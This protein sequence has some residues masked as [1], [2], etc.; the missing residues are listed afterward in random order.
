MPPAS[1][2]LLGEAWSSMKA[3]TETERGLCRRL[4]M[5]DTMRIWRILQIVALA[6]SALGILLQSYEA[7]V[8]GRDPEAVH[9]LDAP[10]FSRRINST[11]SPSHKS[12]QSTVSTQITS[13]SWIAEHAGEPISPHDASSTDTLTCP[14]C[15]NS[16]YVRSAHTRSDGAFVAR[17]FSHYPG[18]TSRSEGGSGGCTGESDIHQRYKSVT[19]SKLQHHFDEYITTI[20]TE[21]TIG[22]RRADL[23]ATFT[24]DLGDRE[25]FLPTHGAIGTKLAVE[26]QHR[27][28]QK[29]KTAVTKHFLNHGYSVLWLEETQFSGK[30]VK[31][32][33]GPGQ[34]WIPVYPNILDPTILDNTS[35]PLNWTTHSELLTDIDTSATTVPAAVPPHWYRTELKQHLATTGAGPQYKRWAALF[36]ELADQYRRRAE[37]AL[38]DPD[39]LGQKLT[40]RL[41][42]LCRATMKTHASAE[43]IPVK[44]A[45]CG[46][47]RHHEDDQYR[48]DP[49]HIICWRNQPT[50][51]SNRP[52]K[53]T[54]DDDFAIDCP[55]FSY[56]PWLDEHTADEMNIHPRLRKPW[57]IDNL[58]GEGEITREQRKA[59]LKY[60]YYQTWGNEDWCSLVFS[61][62]RE[63]ALLRELDSVDARP[64]AE[65]CA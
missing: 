14:H 64:S 52:K 58:R 8:S 5:T 54:L 4:S 22:E 49:E 1:P 23:A 33:D 50:Q 28:E 15:N 27:H 30:D 10:P 17:H 61:P 40:Q 16:L 3:V 39:A 37:D 45:V 56:H 31:L 38:E 59:A 53:L 55:H 51:S 44:N 57:F 6:L 60:A 26:V 63:E 21:V 20:D 47:C 2:V 7:S 48:P 34:T 13:M 9:Q 18:E 43:R 35:I 62:G 25:R 12:L 11:F 41:Y 46:N 32:L 42:P 65:D 29:D 36:P 19:L 24:E